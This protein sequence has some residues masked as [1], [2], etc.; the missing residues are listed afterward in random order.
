MKE[1]L[2]HRFINL[3]HR[4]DRLEGIEKNLI[5]H[6]FSTER[7]RLSAV[8]QSK[9]PLMGCAMSHHQALVDL[10]NSSKAPYFLVMEDDWR[11]VV[12]KDFIIQLV[13]GVSD[14]VPDW[15]VVQLSAT[16]SVFTKIGPIKVGAAKGHVAKLHKATSAA[17]Y[18]VRR[19]YVPTLKQYFAMSISMHEQNSEKLMDINE[20]YYSEN[21]N[22]NPVNV[23]EK[24]SVSISALD[25]IWVIGQMLHNF[26]GTSIRVG[27]C[28]P[29]ESDISPYLTDNSKRQ[30]STVM[31]DM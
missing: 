31:R 5:A 1:I 11:F 2:D 9:L 26:I 4:R 22:Q 7:K 10:E 15:D 20:K 12:E 29:S 6:G 8:S 25:H 18:I 16:D 17:A 14:E 24:L 19:G 13:E 3:S 28:Q 30:L 23:H 21:G 27:Y